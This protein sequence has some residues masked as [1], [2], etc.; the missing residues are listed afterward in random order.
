MNLHF[1]ISPETSPETLRALLVV[2][3]ETIPQGIAPPFP[4]A[5]PMA[6]PVSSARPDTAG[7]IEKAWRAANPGRARAFR[8][9]PGISREATAARLLAG[10]D[11]TGNEE[12]G[13]ILNET[14]VY[15]GAGEYHA[16]SASDFFPDENGD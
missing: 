15:T 8:T 9:E 6:R 5:R 14:P 10:G 1:H 4:M 3:A 2:I 16:P 11:E 13:E 7:P 12:T